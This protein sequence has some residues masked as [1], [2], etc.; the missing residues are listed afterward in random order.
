MPVG[1]VVRL[2]FIGGDFLLNSPQ[3]LV[4]QRPEM[5]FPVI[6]FLTER[7]AEDSDQLIQGFTKPVELLIG[8]C[9]FDAVG[10]RPANFRNGHE[11]ETT[12]KGRVSASFYS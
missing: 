12:E 7:L 3:I 5:R 11:Y 4:D 9:F 2:L 6:P 8:N 10:K 1:E